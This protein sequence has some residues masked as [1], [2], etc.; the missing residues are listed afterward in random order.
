MFGG[1]GLYCGDSFFGIVFGGRLYFKTNRETRT[2]YTEAGM[3]YFSPRPEQALK[4]YREVPVD[5]IE[6][7]DKLVAWAR[8]AVQLGNMTT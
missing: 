8:E 7:D 2:K 5:V 6:N 4:N 3:G 1:H